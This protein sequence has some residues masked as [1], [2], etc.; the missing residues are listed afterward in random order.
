MTEKNK[1][2]Y[3]KPTVTAFVLEIALYTSGDSEVTVPDP[4]E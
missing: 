3:C 2:K 4:F 1:K